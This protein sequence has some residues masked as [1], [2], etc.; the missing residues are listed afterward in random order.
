MT[1]IVSGPGVGRPAPA[2]DQFGLMPRPMWPTLLFSRMW[3]DAGRLLPGI[4]EHFVAMRAAEQHNIASGIA[5]ASKPEHGLFESKMDLFDRTEHEGLKQLI[6]FFEDSVRQAVWMVNGRQLDP[7]GIRVV[8]E[9]SWFHVT[10]DG[11]FHD[12]HYHGGCSW[13]GI[14]YVRA[15]DAP[16]SQPKHAGNG[17]NRFYSPFV[18]GGLLDDYGNKYLSSN[19]QDVPPR[20]GLLILFPA[21]MLHS[22]LPYTG[23]TDRIVIAFNTSSWVGPVRAR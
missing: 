5:E 6:A 20:D 21:Y 14:F 16:T 7:F 9:D 8:F 18:V 2:P 3:K 4:A 13:C 1:T 10:N 15:G 23:K 22:A 12:A 19:L 17:I 11:G